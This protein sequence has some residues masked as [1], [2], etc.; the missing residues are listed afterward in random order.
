MPN[1]L[2]VAST[3]LSILALGERA[4][5]VFSSCLYTVWAGVAV[6]CCSADLVIQM[7]NMLT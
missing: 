6:L 5:T 7:K 1:K 3:P 2:Q 4:G